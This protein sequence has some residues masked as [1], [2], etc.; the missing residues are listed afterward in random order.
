MFALL[1]RK[2]AEEEGGH[3]WGGIDIGRDLWNHWRTSL[4][5]ISSCLYCQLVS[6]ASS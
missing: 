3:E 1:L 6:W 5:Y 4:V 2:S